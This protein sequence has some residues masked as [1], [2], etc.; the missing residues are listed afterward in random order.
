MVGLTESMR[1]SASIRLNFKEGVG[2]GMLKALGSGLAVFGLGPTEL[3][4]ILVILLLIFG[5]SRL[6][7]LGRGLG[8]SMRE[9][10]RSMGSKEEETGEKEAKADEET[11]EENKEEKDEKKESSSDKD[12]KSS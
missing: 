5:A 11:K 4:I 10:R 3:V 2:T 6:P 9:L 12:K 1:L 8:E 7:E